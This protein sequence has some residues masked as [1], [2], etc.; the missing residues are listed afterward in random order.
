MSIFL[1]WQEG[2]NGEGIE[3]KSDK[4]GSCGQTKQD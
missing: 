1:A 4:E 3:E 2:I